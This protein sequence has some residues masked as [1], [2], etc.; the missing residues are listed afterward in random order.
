MFEYKWNVF[1][2]IYFVLEYKCMYL[3]SKTKCIFKY[4][5]MPVYAWGYGMHYSHNFHIIRL[6]TAYNL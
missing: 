5:C 6:Y 2:T 4:K 1:F 3:F